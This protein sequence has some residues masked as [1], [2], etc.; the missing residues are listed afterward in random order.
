MPIL[1]GTNVL[2]SCGQAAQ[3]KAALAVHMSETHDPL[4]SVVHRFAAGVETEMLVV[5]EMVQSLIVTC[6][7]KD[8]PLF[9]AGA[10]GF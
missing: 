1:V 5:T 2:Q 8:S 7:V 6:R 10:V 9:G 3:S 4:E